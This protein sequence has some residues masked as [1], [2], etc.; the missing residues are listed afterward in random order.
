MNGNTLNKTLLEKD[1]EQISYYT[2]EE[3]QTL[4][5]IF[6]RMMLCTSNYVSSLNKSLITEK[7][8]NS[9]SM[10]AILE[11]KRIKY[12]NVLNNAIKRYDR[13]STETVNKFNGGL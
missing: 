2:S 6:E 4:N 11:S 1:I 3:K 7:I 5:K 12:T 10:V 9:Q 13:V 8:N